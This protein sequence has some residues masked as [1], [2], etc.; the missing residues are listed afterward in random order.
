MNGHHISAT[1]NNTCTHPKVLARMQTVLD[2][3]DIC[4][5]WSTGSRSEK[6]PPTLFHIKMYQQSNLEPIDVHFFSVFSLSSFFFFFYFF[7]YEVLVALGTHS[8]SYSYLTLVYLNFTLPLGG[9]NSDVS[10]FT[11][12]LGRERKGLGMNKVTKVSYRVSGNIRSSV[13][14][15]KSHEIKFYMSQMNFHEYSQIKQGV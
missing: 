3:D 4:Q 2:N 14:V 12:W 1:N 9:R 6:N 10:F 13:L 8:H 15:C 5:I 7:R 11:Y